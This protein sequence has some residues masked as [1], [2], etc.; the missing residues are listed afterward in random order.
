LERCGTGDGNWMGTVEGGPSRASILCCKQ[1]R[2]DLE[3]TRGI[4][5][6]RSTD[7]GARARFEAWGNAGDALPLMK[8]VKRQFDPAWE[9]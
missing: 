5:G 7:R 4:V 1:L 6:A 3:G 8:A 9:L 2:S